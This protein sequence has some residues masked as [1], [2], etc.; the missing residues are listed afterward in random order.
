MTNQ[1]SEIINGEKATELLRY[2]IDSRRLCKIRIPNTPY[3]WITLLSDIRREEH[4]NF[5]LIDGVPGFEKALSHSKNREVTLE[6]KDR[7]G[8]ACHFSVRVSKIFPKMIWVESPGIIYRVQRRKFY[9]LEAQGETEIVFR[10][11]PETEERAK[12]RDY[13]LGGVA[14]ST[15]RPLPLKTNDQ[16]EDLCLRIPE[17]GDW[18]TIPIPLAVVRR[19]DSQPGTFLYAAEFLEMSD[20]TR[21]QLARHIFERQRLLLRKLGKNLSFPSP[22]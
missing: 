2:L 11:P 15:A 22:F 3:C 14:F 18:L 1:P 12:V 9:R 16:L 19:V 6:Y 10:V 8:I 21:K 20:T 7:G 5:L 13:S 4:S 17:E